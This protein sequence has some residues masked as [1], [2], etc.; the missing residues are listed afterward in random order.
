MWSVQTP[1]THSYVPDHH[2]GKGLGNHNYCRNPDNHEGGLWCYT[3][4]ENLRWGECH[5]LGFVTAAG[6]SRFTLKNDANIN[7]TFTSSE[8]TSDFTSSDVTVTGGGTLSSFTGSGTT[9]T[10]TFTPAVAGVHSIKVAAGA[11]TDSA[12]NGNFESDT[13][14]FFDSSI[15]VVS[16]TKYPDAS[17]SNP[18]KGEGPWV[19]LSFAPS[20]VEMV[21]IL[22]DADHPSHFGS[23]KIEWTNITYT[24]KD[25]SGE[26][27]GSGQEVRMYSNS[28]DNPGSTHEQ[29]MEHCAIAC[30][31]HKTPKLEYGSVGN[32]GGSVWPSEYSAHG[33]IIAITSGRCYCENTTPEDCVLM[34]PEHYQRYDFSS[35]IPS[36]ESTAW[37]ECGRYEMTDVGPREFPCSTHGASASAIKITMLNAD[38]S[39]SLPEIEIHTSFLHGGQ[40]HGY[41][42]DYDDNMD[43]YA[44]ANS[45]AY[46]SWVLS[47]TDL[48]EEC[49]RTCGEIGKPAFLIQERD[50]RCYCSSYSEAE[51]SDNWVSSSTYSSYDIIHSPTHSRITDVGQGVC[52]DHDGKY[53]AWGWLYL[54]LIHI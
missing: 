28:N 35:A 34:S 48:K 29:Q 8:F 21:T 46:P 30:M 10:A 54:S 52:R 18:D 20:R 53:P 15:S 22:N 27:T 32:Y 43:I 2:P 16:D 39:L 44:Y 41:C 33:F 26:C 4:D 9:Y 25:A 24:K 11:Y 3:T 14:D 23:F 17:W 1:H 45:Y 47:W 50:A 51:C 31:S 6:V 36:G 40:R 12:G 42:G 49:A 13:L 19:V 7:L 38:H 37:N 5:P